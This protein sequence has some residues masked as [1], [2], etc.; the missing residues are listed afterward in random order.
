MV[1]LRVVLNVLV[2]VVLFGLLVYV[3][4]MVCKSSLSS[5]RATSDGIKFKLLMSFCVII[6]EMEII[7]RWLL[8]SFFN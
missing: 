3:C 6:F 8:L 5:S 7:V 2:Y 1:V 4:F